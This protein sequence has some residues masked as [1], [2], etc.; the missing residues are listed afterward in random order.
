MEL[1][2]LVEQF[3]ACGVKFV[4]VVEEDCEQ[5]EVLEYDLGVDR[6]VLEDVSETRPVLDASANAEK[7]ILMIRLKPGLQDLTTSS[8][9]RRTSDH[10]RAWPQVSVDRL[11]EQRLWAHHFFVDSGRPLTG[12]S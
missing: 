5:V 11:G 12:R 4:G 3:L 7:P 10:A 6:L 2:S 8:S 9:R 1:D